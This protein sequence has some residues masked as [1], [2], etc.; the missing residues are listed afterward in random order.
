[1]CE[2]LLCPV[3]ACNRTHCSKATAEKKTSTKTESMIHICES[4]REK[5]ETHIQTDS[6]T[7]QMAQ[8]GNFYFLK[9]GS[10]CIF[11]ARSKPHCP[12]PCFVTPSINTSSWDSGERHPPCG[13]DACYHWKA[14][15]LT[16]KLLWNFSTNPTSSS[17]LPPPLHPSLFSF[18]ERLWMMRLQMRRL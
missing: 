8:R 15:N 16:A 9:N 11:Q 2:K 17:T 4:A 14:A 10:K 3:K 12:C 13:N 1:M 6:L 7:A 18:K 5:K